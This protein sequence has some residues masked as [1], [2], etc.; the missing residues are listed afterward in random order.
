MTGKKVTALIYQSLLLHFLHTQHPATTTYPTSPTPTTIT[1][2]RINSQTQPIYM[3]LD[4][5]TLEPI[6]VNTM[7]WPTMVNQPGGLLKVE[8]VA[9]DSNGDVVISG[10]FGESE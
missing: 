6:W 9:I 10:Y 4:A 8:G 2:V 5:A 1:Q 7:L 3:K